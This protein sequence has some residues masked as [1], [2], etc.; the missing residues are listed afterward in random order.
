M[1]PIKVPIEAF[2]ALPNFNY[3]V[4]SPD[5]APTKGPII[6]PSGP[7]INSPKSKPI[8]A[9]I[10]PFLVPPNF[11]KPIIGIIMSKVNT[12]T[13]IIKLINRKE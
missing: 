7:R 13:A 4:I 1:N 5:R 9:P 10:I 8:V 2:T 12:N 3:P 11:F 6:L